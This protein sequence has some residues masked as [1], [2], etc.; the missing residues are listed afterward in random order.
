MPLTDDATPSRRP[1]KSRQTGWARALAAAL[2]RRRVRPNTIS[3]LSVLFA[4][5]AGAALWMAPAAGRGVAMALHLVAA[6]AI[7]LRLL[8][9]LLDGM[10][11]VEGGMGSKTGELWNDLPDRFADA[12][13]L[14]GVGYALR[15]YGWERGVE[16]G[17]LATVLAILTAYVR[18][19]GGAAGAS[20]P[21][22]GPMAKPHRM[23]TVTVACLLAVGER[24]LSWPP[25]A[26]ALAL[27]A[28]VAGSAATVVR[29]T[30]RIAR[31]LGAGSR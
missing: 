15:G 6:A 20:Q 30:L 16:L 7:Q 14:L 26:L 31:E 22:C 4:A 25:R 18:V 11:A 1:L 21:F 13:V 28:I 8:C 19:L 12:L 29:R 24:W 2:V 23:A 3:A 27:V 17:W 10:V 9:N 5:L